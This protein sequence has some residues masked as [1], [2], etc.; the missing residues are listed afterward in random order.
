MGN[1]VRKLSD[2]TGSMGTCEVI[3]NY[4]GENDGNVE[5]T[6][7]FVSYMTTENG[8]ITGKVEAIGNSDDVTC[9]VIKGSLIVIYA[10]GAQV[11]DGSF[12]VAGGAEYF[13][14]AVCNDMLYPI[15]FYTITGDCRFDLT[16]N[17]SW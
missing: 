6:N 16:N 2:A 15:N 10:Y 5:H 8:S 11:E 4:S 12:A 9:N 7:G 3:I 13:A 1:E 17:E 14:Q